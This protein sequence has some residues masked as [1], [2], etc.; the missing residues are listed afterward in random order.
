MMS[1][2]A[3]GS[4]SAPFTFV[5][6]MVEHRVHVALQRVAALAESM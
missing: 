1:H 4:A 2:Q 5:E 3:F 6:G